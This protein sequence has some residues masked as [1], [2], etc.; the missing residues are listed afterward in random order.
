VEWLRAGIVSSRHEM[1]R[2]VASQR[3]RPQEEPDDDRQ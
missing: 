3:P 2:S 1:N